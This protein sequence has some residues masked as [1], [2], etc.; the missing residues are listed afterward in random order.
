MITV[1]GVGFQAMSSQNSSQ[2]MSSHPFGAQKAAEYTAF[3]WHLACYG[4]VMGIHDM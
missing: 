1:L 4:H 2:Q 3:H